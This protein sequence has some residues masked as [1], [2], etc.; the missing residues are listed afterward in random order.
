MNKQLYYLLILDKSGSMASVQKQTVESVNGE[1]SLIKN[2]AKEENLDVFVSVVAFSSIFGKPN[3]VYIYKNKNVQDIPE[4]A[5]K[6]YIPNGGTPLRDAIGDSVVTLQK[7]LDTRINDENVNVLVSIFTDG[8]ENTSREY[9]HQQIADMIDGLSKTGKW[10][11]TFIGCGGIQAVQQVA[12][13]YNF[14][15]SNVAAYDGSKE[16]YLAVNS[17]RSA[18]VCNLMTSYSVSGCLPQEDFFT[19]SLTKEEKPV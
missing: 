15:A 5:E 12:K 18:S 14:S 8:E 7:E 3:N 13:S 9:S 2:K 10:V 16:G 19:K 11:F 1:I 4:L 17:T 6:D